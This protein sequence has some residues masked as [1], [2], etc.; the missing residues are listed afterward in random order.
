VH[1]LNHHPLGCWLQKNRAWLVNAYLFVNIAGFTA[2]Q[3]ANPVA[4]GRFSVVEI[5]FI[6]QNLVLAG[7]VLLRR[8]HRSVDPHAGHQLIALAAFFSGALFVGQPAGVDADLHNLSEA[9]VLG[10]NL[11][12]IA[13]LFNLGRSFGILIACRGVQ[14]GGLYRL[15][16]HPMYLSDILLRVGYTISHFTV[17]TVCLVLFS[18]GLYVW[19][20][21][22]EEEFLTNQPDYRTYM[23][24]VRY[25]LLPGIF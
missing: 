10:A 1:F 19:R 18:I 4:T 11:L 14:T 16:R 7:V 15:I 9:V 25:R 20:A 8:D 6:A 24:H 17:I 13:T 22:L 3:A 12:G 5:A 23:K 2:W 21:L